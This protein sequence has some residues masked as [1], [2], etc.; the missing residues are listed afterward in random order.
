MRTLFIPLAQL[1]GIFLVFRPLCYIAYILYW[2]LSRAAVGKEPVLESAFILALPMHIV[3]LLL[4]LLL[5]FKTEK[6]AAVLK[7]PCDTTSSIMIDS[8]S[9]LRVGLVLIGVYTVVQAAPTLI[10]A[11]VFILQ[12]AGKTPGIYQDKF[13]TSM[14]QTVL[15]I[16]LVLQARRLAE[17]L[18]KPKNM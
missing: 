16:S 10:G 6:I 13:W 7:I 18:N 9:V 1:L 17:F 2:L 5:I 8:D 14:L 15:G 11:V 4:G 3:G 12:Q